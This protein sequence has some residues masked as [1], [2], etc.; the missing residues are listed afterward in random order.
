MRILLALL[1]FVAARRGPRAGLVPFL[2]LVVALTGL[3]SPA[4]GQGTPTP[5]AHGYRGADQ[6]SGYAGDFAALA[7]AV[8]AFWAQAFGSAAIIYAPPA[9]VTVDRPM[10]TG[11]GPTAL[12]DTPFYCSVDSTIYL[13]DWFM[14]GAVADIGDFAAIMVLAHEWGHHVQTL[15]NAPFPGSKP[16]ELQADCLAG[17]YA[18]EAEQQGLLDPG[19]VTEGVL[20]SASVGDPTW[21]PQDSPGAHGTND[22]RI[23]AFMRGYI[24]GLGDCELPG[25]AEDAPDQGG[26]PAPEISASLPTALP[27]GHGA[28]FRVEADSVLGFDDLAGRLGGTEEAVRPPPGVGGWQASAHRVFRLRPP[29]GR[30]CRVGRHRACIGFADA[31]AAQEAVDHF[32]AVRAEDTSL[33]ARRATRLSGGTTR[34][35]PRVRPATG[36]EH[37]RL[38]S[39]AIAHPGHRG[40]AERLPFLDVRRW[41][42]R[43]SPR[44]ARAGADPAA[45]PDAVRP[46]TATMPAEP[47]PTPA[48]GIAAS[49]PAALPLAHA[50][51]FAADDPEVYDFPTL[52]ARFPGVPDAAARCRTSG[53]GRAPTASSAATTRH[54]GAWTGST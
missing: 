34:P 17:V 16:F 39:G 44:R 31:A 21:M 1:V 38:R 27:L 45:V 22:E 10:S 54:R 7:T 28:C 18:K 46:P 19:D 14:D 41:R 24:N 6:A 23:T 11:C 8:D 42:R 9:V 30:R 2:L 36:R 37:T 3:G 25:F 40:F 43:Y 29:P 50:A 35:S 32:A 13:H 52:V 4:A 20:M 33:R 48:T 12:T 15:A 51:C 53:G 26:D 49:L 5:L 47:T